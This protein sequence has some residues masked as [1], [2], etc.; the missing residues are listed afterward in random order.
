ML[1]YRTDT[2]QF[3]QFTVRYY[4]LTKKYEKFFVI[5]LVHGKADI[6]EQQRQR[7]CHVYLSLIHFHLLVIYIWILNPIPWA[8]PEEGEG[9]WLLS[10]LWAS[11]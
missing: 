9:M 3:L 1:M 11:M 8:D 5:K 6:F 4:V 10:V 7:L 2:T